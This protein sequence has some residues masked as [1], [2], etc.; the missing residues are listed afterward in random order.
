VAD[1]DD[2]AERARQRDVV[3]RGYDTISLAYRGDDGATAAS[4]AEGVTP[5]CGL[6]GG[7]GWPAATGRAD[8]GAASGRPGGM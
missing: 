1:S 7:T 4:S 3:R 6:D 5:L 2:L 8:V